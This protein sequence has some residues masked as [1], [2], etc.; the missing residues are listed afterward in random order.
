MQ[1]PF[2]HPDYTPP[3]EAPQARQPWSIPVPFLSTPEGL[4]DAIARATAA[5]GLPGC[6][7]CKARQER[8]NRAATLRPWDW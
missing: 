3:Q 5:I 7:P 8:M 4:G 6:A 2:D 1:L